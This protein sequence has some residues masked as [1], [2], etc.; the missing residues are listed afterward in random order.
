[1]PPSRWFLRNRYGTFDAVGWGHPPHQFS[2]GNNQYY[3][4]ILIAGLLRWRFREPN[5]F[6]PIHDT[7]GEV[8]ADLL[9]RASNRYDIDQRQ[10]AAYQ[11]VLDAI[12]DTGARPDL[13]Q[14][15]FD[16]L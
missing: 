7:K 10:R 9:E 8:F 15:L 13:L 14:T 1:M 16:L 2:F 6:A 5:A 12:S 3:L 4:P 11:T